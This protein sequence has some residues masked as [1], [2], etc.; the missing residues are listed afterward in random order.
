MVS[1]LL[2]WWDFRNVVAVG[3]PPLC[4]QMGRQLPSRRPRHFGTKCPK[5]SVRDKALQG[6]VEPVQPVDQ[7]LGHGGQ[8]KG[9]EHKG[10]YERIYPGGRIPPDKPLKNSAHGAE[11]GEHPK[12]P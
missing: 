12:E 7:P 6:I 2:M 9:R 1:P 8:A 5:V 3:I 10:H 11:Q 4:K